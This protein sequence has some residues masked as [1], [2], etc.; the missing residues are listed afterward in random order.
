MQDCRWRIDQAGFIRT[1]NVRF[2][3][4]CS[5]VV[6]GGQVGD[7]VHAVQIGRDRQRAS[8]RDGAEDRQGGV[9]IAANGR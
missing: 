9:T 7:F 4:F 3:C 5:P 1:P 2:F 6:R 8:D